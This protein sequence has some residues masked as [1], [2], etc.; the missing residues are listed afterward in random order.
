MRTRVLLP[1]SLLLATL[2]ACSSTS[3]PP[4]SPAP[5][6][7]APPSATPDTTPTFTDVRV[8]D[9]T[10]IVRIR[11]FTAG[12]NRSVVVEPVIFLKKPEFCKAFGIPADDK[13]C[14]AP[15]GI[16]FSD[17]RITLPRADDATY[18]LIDPDDWRK[19]T[20]TDLVAA[21]CKATA[22]EFR[23]WLTGNDDTVLLTTR[24]G[25]AVHFAQ[26]Y[27]PGYYEE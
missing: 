5:S 25:Q 23:K 26:V 1:L 27:F 7:A 15:F 11:A 14:L 21:T 24:G 16:E 4:S 19:C 2:A 13:Q 8:G 20:D 10:S 18:A 6:S 12:R 22:T 9:T 17:A 3:T